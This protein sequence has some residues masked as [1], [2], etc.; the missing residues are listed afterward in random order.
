MSEIVIFKR[1]SGA[2]FKPLSD[3]YKIGGIGLVFVSLSAVIL[4]WSGFVPRGFYQYAMIAI[5]IVLLL[6]VIWLFYLKELRPLADT[7]NKI[8]EK[9]ELIDLMQARASELSVLAE[10]ITLVGIRHSSEVAAILVDLNEYVNKSINARDTVLSVLENPFVAKL[11]GVI[12]INELLKDDSIDAVQK[13]ARSTQ[14]LS[15]RISKTMTE[16][17]HVIEDLRRAFQEADIAPLKKYATYLQQANEN[18]K[19][20]VES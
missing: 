18:I 3:A 12:K 6:P 9:E 19:R 4:I 13:L 8:K 17:K 2:L 10:D 16:T 1:L 20:L 11:P 15:F 7:K 14:E 5:G